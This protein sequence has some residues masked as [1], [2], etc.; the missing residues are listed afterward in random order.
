MS[1][2]VA[3]VFVEPLYEINIGYL[4]RTMKNFGLRELYLINPRC[5]IGLDARKF[6]AHAFDILENAIILDNFKEIIKQFDL[7][8]C[9]TGKKGPKPLRRYITPE[10]LAKKLSTLKGR[11]A[12][13]F[14]REDI[15]LKNDELRLC[16]VVVT[17]ETNP[18]YPILNISH[19]AAIIFYEFF[20]NKASRGPR[21]AMPSREEINVLFKYLGEICGFLGLPDH[22][23]ERSML[24]FRR[25]I[26]ECSISS[27][28]VRLLIG[29]FRKIYELLETKT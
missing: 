14:G 2:R 19:A 5:N 26:G 27:N 11:S 13:V 18:Q 25:I 7:V 1:N 22:R 28:D 15:G 10:A 8:A 17:I 23:R 9:T 21:V 3:V 29:I 20:K 24:T 16:D 4:A 12:I 6:S